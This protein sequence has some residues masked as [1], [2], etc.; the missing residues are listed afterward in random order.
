MKEINKDIATKKKICFWVDTVMEVGGVQRVTS[1][2]ANGLCKYYN[3]TIL[4]S[5]NDNSI[6]RN[7][8]NISEKV[9][10]VKEPRYFNLKKRPFL[11]KILSRI[12]R[13]F[14]VFNINVLNKIGIEIY[15]PKK[16]I[17][18]I[19]EYFNKNSFDLIIGV[20]GNKSSLLGAISTKINCKTWGW[21]HNSYE[22]YFENKYRYHWNQKFLFKETLK[23]L[24]R[25]IVLNEYD[26]KSIKDNFCIHADYIYNPKSFTSDSKSN[27]DKKICL[28]A[29]RFVHAKGFDTLINAANEF[30][31]TNPDWKIYL[32]GD[33]E[34]Y[35]QINEKIKQYNLEDYVILTGYTSDIK[36]Y[37]LKSS[38]FLLPSRWE[39]M[40]MIVLE[41]LEMG[42]PII[43]FD[44]T[45]IKPLVS[46]GIEGLIV[47]KEEGYKG[48]AKAMDR[49][50]SD[51][52]YR[53]ELSKNALTKS[54]IFEVDIII[55]KWIDF[56]E[57]D[58]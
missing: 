11:Y 27:I 56:I 9:S 36:K 49:V 13:Y 7:L 42:T 34:E 44:I 54:K 20:Q 31:K 23:N 3:I 29:G 22:A 25:Y 2:I 30:R 50:A 46:D 48:F 26:A 14:G 1:V 33:G 38:V 32:V 5:D 19:I 4:C 28:A 8:Y 12:N 58:I 10:V 6:K 15:F 55:S 57:K 43:S 40:P 24:D 21:Q 39:G 47:K 41:A 17:N 51:A 16:N 35:K 53:H 37:F 45:A 18:Y 52:N